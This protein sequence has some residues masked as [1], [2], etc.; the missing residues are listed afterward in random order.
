MTSVR[1]IYES[2]EYG[3]APEGDAAARAWLD[4]HDAKFGH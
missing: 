3:P 2:M 4:Q 1:E